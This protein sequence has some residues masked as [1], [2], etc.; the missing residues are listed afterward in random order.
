MGRK[1]M[2]PAGYWITGPWCIGR[3]MQAYWAAWSGPP[4]GLCRRPELGLY[5]G[6]NWARVGLIRKKTNNNANKIK[7]DN[8]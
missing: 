4:L 7:Y 2:G 5:L 6:L 3:E 8:Q 1:A